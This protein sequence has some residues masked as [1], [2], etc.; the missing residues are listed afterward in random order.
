MSSEAGTV[1]R[2]PALATGSMSRMAVD[3]GL[4][5]LARAAGLLDGHG[6]EGVALGDVVGFLPA[7]DLE[8]LA[9]QAHHQH[10]R[11]VGVDGIAP[12]RAL[13]DLVALALAVHAAAG[14][15]HERDDAVDV[16]VVVEHAG[17]ARPRA[18]MKRA[19][20]AEQF[21]RGEDAEVVAGADL[22]VRAAEALEGRLGSATGRIVLRAGILGEVIVAGEIVHARRCARAPTRPARSAWP[23]SR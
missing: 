19:T 14:A 13:Q 16:G 8:D 20:E 7:A 21:T 10:A 22:A 1:S 2:S 11:H 4:D 6:A 15:V 5:G 17:A 23:R 9:A 18:A 12:L 3:A